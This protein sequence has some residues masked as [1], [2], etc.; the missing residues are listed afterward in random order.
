[1]S[2]SFILLHTECVNQEKDSI[3]HVILVPVIDGVRQSTVDLIVDPKAPFEVVMSGIS[4]ETVEEAPDFEMCWPQ[5]YD[6]LSKS[7]IMVSSAEGYSA[8]ALQATL[9]RLGISYPAIDYVNA[10]AICRRSLN[11]VSYSLNYLSG[12]F[13]KDYILDTDPVGIATR[14][15][16]LAI[17]ALEGSEAEDIRQFANQA[18]IK[19]GVISPD[20]LIPSR[21]IKIKPTGSNK[22][23]DTS[24]IVVNADPENPFYEMNVVFTGKMESM[25]RDE[26]RSAVV[27]VGGFAPDRL[28][29]DTNFLVVGKQDLRV[30]GE[31]GLSGKMKTAAKYKEKGCDIEV[32]NEPEFI[33][34]LGEAN[35]YK[36]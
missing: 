35:I 10:K 5:I 12:I 14:W 36:K 13:Y 4:R 26:G 20:G 27:S 17:K 29:M 31:R 18:K 34:M 24:G 22:P 16:D 11:E 23:F 32:I 21:C 8:W 6:M 33:E 30:V 19:I 3:C 15:A 9:S 25:T 7:P 1:M 2:P 28:T